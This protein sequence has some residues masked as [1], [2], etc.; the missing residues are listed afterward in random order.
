MVIDQ[1]GREHPRQEVYPLDG[2][3]GIPVRACLDRHDELALLAHSVDFD[4]LYGLEARAY[5]LR[6]LGKRVDYY[7]GDIH[8]YGSSIS[9]EMTQKTLRNPGMLRLPPPAPY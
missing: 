4:P 7:A 5:G 6:T 2:F 3:E 9:T 1:R 8:R